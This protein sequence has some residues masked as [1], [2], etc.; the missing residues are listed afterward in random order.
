MN[1][2]DRYNTNAKSAINA[3]EAALR[4]CDLSERLRCLKVAGGYVKEA[5]TNLLNWR[6]EK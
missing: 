2:L 6:E 1:D 4:S 5:E 3:L